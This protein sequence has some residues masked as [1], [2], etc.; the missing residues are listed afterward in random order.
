VPMINFKSIAKVIIIYLL[1]ILLSSCGEK[2]EIRVID[3]SLLEAK[4]ELSGDNSR[5]TAQ[6]FIKVRIETN[7]DLIPYAK[8]N[9]LN[10]WYDVKGCQSKTEYRSWPNIYR[11]ENSA[12][13]KYQYDFTFYYKD[14][15]K[16]DVSYNLAENPETLCFQFAAAGMNPFISTKTKV[17]QYKMTEK[18]I[19]SLKRY[20]DE[21]GVVEFSYGAECANRICVPD[22]AM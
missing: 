10:L 5:V 4:T 15:Q 7:L 1:V 3:L 20:D 18:F 6:G 11:V 19:Q 16:M 14:D 9:T 13:S 17:I 2:I 21:S 8:K 22:Y 12:A